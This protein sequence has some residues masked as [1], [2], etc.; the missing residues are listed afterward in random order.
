MLEVVLTTLSFAEIKKQIRIQIY[1]INSLQTHVTWL[2]E[3]K[4]ATTAVGWQ[5]GSVTAEC[6]ISL[7]LGEGASR[8]AVTHCSSWVAILQGIVNGHSLQAI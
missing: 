3:L 2:D 6:A 5:S 7:Q 4:T 1:K 8:T